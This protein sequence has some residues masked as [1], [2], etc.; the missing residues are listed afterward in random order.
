MNKKTIY[1]II[2]IIL[3]AI[4]GGYWYWTTT[5]QYSLNQVKDAV[6]N[7]DVTQFEKYVDVKS[8][9]SRLIDDVLEEATKNNQANSGA[10]KIGE[11]LGQGFVQLMKPKLV[12][13][14][15]EQILRSVEKGEIDVSSERKNDKANIENISNEI[16][17]KEDLIEGISYTKTE[18]STAYVGLDFNHAQFDTVLTLELLM[19]D[20]GGYWQI[21]EVSNFSKLNEQIDNIER[22]KLQEVNQPV[23]N[24]ISDVLTVQSIGKENISAGFS[25]EVKFIVSLKNSSTK[26][27]NKFVAELNAK[28][29]KGELIKTFKIE[30]DEIID[31]NSTINLERFADI[32]MFDEASN[33]LYEIDEGDMTFD[34]AF[35]KVVLGEDTLT[36]YDSYS[37]YEYQ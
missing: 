2:G 14:A 34:L 11:A 12:E 26:P 31:S 9:T 23:R 6:S 17:F 19:R 15:E 8:V 32:N 35:K 13:M 25:K 16:G 20:I 7:N 5:P 4:I 21:A 30:N 29:S 37:E 27:V 18:G 1:I 24:R 10:E 33:R 36:I 22:Q 3:I 28:D